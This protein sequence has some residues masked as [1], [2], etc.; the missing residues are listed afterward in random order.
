MDIVS[1]RG[2]QFISWVLKTFCKALG[3]TASLSTG[4]YHQTNGQAEQANQDL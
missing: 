1:D 4:F 3:T 2:P